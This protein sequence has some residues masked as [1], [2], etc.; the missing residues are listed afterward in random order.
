MFS[1]MMADNEY[2]KKFLCDT[3][4]DIADLPV[5]DRPGCT[6]YVISTGTTYMLNHKEEWIRQPSINGGN[7]E[8]LMQELE[9]L[10][11]QVEELR[12]DVDKL[13]WELIPEEK[14]EII[15]EDNSISIPDEVAEINQEAKSLVLA[16]DDTTQIVGNVLVLD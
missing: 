3:T 13:K 2:F 15:I 10:K 7:E 14:E 6:A 8:I 11:T 12:I 9:T 16:D 5:Y 1:P 4:E